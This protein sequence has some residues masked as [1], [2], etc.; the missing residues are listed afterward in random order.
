MKF[1][2]IRVGSDFSAFGA[3]YRLKKIEKSE[4]LLYNHRTGQTFTYGLD[5]LK[6]TIRQAGYVLIEE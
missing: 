5:A 6:R 4:A 2:E 1:R 3:L